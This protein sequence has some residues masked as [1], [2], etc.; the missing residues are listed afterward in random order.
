[1]NI[2]ILNGPNLNLL[3]TREPE[4]YGNMSMETYLEGLKKEFKPTA[5]DYMQINAESL[6]IELI[7]QAPRKYHGLVFNPGA[8]SHYSLAVADAI[9]SISIPVI[10]VHV[11]NIYA[12]ESFR[13]NS[14]ISKHCKGVI[15]GLGLNGYG[16]AVRALF[17][18]NT[19][20]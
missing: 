1:M 14:F 8:F 12:R 18:L 7:H 11:S 17:E 16:M 20:V 15:S 9:A 10:E 6:L 3:G 4:I 5:I 2:L 19:P 13:Q